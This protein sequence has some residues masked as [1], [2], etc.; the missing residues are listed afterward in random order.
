MKTDNT[1]VTILVSVESPD[2]LK[3]TMAS[4]NELFKTDFELLEIIEDEIDFC[5]IGISQSN[6]EMCFYLGISYARRQEKLM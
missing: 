5:K 1:P 2:L 3:E 6:L 4:F